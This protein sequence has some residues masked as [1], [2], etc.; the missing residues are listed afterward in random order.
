[1]G[2]HQSDLA[3]VILRDVSLLAA[4]H[5]W[6]AVLAGTFILQAMAVTALHDLRFGMKVFALFV[7]ELKHEAFVTLD[8]S[9]EIGRELATWKRGKAI[10]HREKI[11]SRRRPVLAIRPLRGERNRRRTRPRSDLMSQPTQSSR[12]ESIE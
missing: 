10:S 1:M 12:G 11:L 5:P 4:K 2:I 6:L 9:R 3:A 8:V 7:R